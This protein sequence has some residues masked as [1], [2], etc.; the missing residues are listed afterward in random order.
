MAN[1]RDLWMVRSPDTGKKMKGPRHGKGKRWLVSWVGP[2][3]ER[4]SEAF[5]GKEA[6]D[7]KKR[8]VESDISTGSYVSKKAAATKVA[9]LWPVWF[10]TKDGL[11]PATRESY[12]ASWRRNVEEKWGGRALS[13]ITAL[14]VE[15]WLASSTLKPATMQRALVVLKGLL[16][17]AVRMNLLS[18]SPITVVLRP[19][20]A[21]ALKRYLTVAQVADLVEAAP[22]QRVEIWTLATCGLRRGELF[23][24]TVG[25]LDAH[26]SRLSVHAAVSWVG[27][28]EDVGTTKSGKAR[29]VPV[30]ASV[31]AMLKKK[32]EGKTPDA[33][34]L[35]APDGSRW[36]PWSWRIR[37]ERARKVLPMKEFGTH[38]L[39]HTAASLAIQSGAN[40]KA[41]QQMLGHATAAMT[42]DVYGHLWDD[43]LDDV[44][45]RLDAMV[46]GAAGRQRTEN[47]PAVMA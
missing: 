37:W 25:D 34:L 42:L 40:V 9:E 19:K 29:S 8:D 13:S 7:A 12:E 27:G 20:K 45:S 31:L 23:A 39:R 32:A 41:V 4:E 1:V 21:T 44:G 33:L 5:H 2:A 26:R 3:G 15:Q 6:A 43:H 17:T 30:P 22:D 14:E 36:D 18:H 11:K 47:E 35:P 46:S 16:N 10:A 38:E 24:L 28:V